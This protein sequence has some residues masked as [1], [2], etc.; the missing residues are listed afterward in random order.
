MTDGFRLLPGAL[1]RSSQADILRAIVDI[2]ENAPL[3]VPVMPRTGKPFSVKMTNCG[4]LGW[5]SDHAGYRYQS[6]HPETKN[7]WPPI[8]EPILGLWRDLADYPA[9]P[10]ACL[11]NYYAPEAKMGLHVDADEKDFS[12]PIVSISLGCS[13]RFRL[14]GP[15]RKGPTRSLKLDSGDIVILAGKSRLF[16]HG[17]DR[18]FPGSSTLLD[19]FSALFPEGG[20]INLTLR[21]VSHILST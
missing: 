17:I 21:R 15:E 1:D 20:R 4:P 10:E 12:A 3:F 5:V 19:P 14:G 8:P 13:A 9:A 16:Y 6:I 18:I 7:P 11:V 2:I